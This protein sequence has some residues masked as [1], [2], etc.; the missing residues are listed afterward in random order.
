MK[1]CKSQHTSGSDGAAAFFPLPFASAFFAGGFVASCATLADHAKT[2]VMH[3]ILT[4]PSQSKFTGNGYGSHYSTSKLFEK[5]SEIHTTRPQKKY[6]YKWQ[7]RVKINRVSSR[8]RKTGLRLESTTRL[9]Q[10]DKCG[11]TSLTVA[12]WRTRITQHQLYD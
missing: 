6:N 3:T 7:E 9:K 1:V 4:F 2:C 11:G 5:R 8:L 10:S 12:S